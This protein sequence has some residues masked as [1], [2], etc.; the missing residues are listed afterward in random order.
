M[1]SC[2]AYLEAKEA[3]YQ[4]DKLYA[5]S[6]YAEALELYSQSCDFFDKRKN[7][8]I[9]FKDSII[10]YFDMFFSSLTPI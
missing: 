2:S 9:S 4:A 5:N 8:D 10:E 7:T 6:K 1:F 3:C